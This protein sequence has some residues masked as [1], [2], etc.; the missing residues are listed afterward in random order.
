MDYFR[1]RSLE[2][3]KRSFLYHGDSGLMRLQEDVERELYTRLYES[4]HYNDVFT[5]FGYSSWMA[6]QVVSNTANGIHTLRLCT[7]NQRV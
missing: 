2:M 5:Y 3:L 6:R 4:E 1:I 7:K